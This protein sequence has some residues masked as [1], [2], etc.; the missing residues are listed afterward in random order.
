MNKLLAARLREAALYKTFEPG[1]MIEAANR[2]EYLEALLSDVRRA[3]YGDGSVVDMARLDAALGSSV[4][5]CDEGG[6]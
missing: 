5:N 6:K 3:W 4:E 2:I 1:D